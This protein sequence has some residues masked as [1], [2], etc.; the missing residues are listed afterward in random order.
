MQKYI[1]LLKKLRILKKIQDDINKLLH[2]STVWQL[3]LNISKCKCVHYGHKNPCHKY[4]LGNQDLAEDTTE[5]D[6][7]VTFDQSLKFSIH[8]KNMV[9]KAN[10]RLG[11]IKRSFSHLN[12]RSFKLL[13]KS[14]VRPILEY[15]SVI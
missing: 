14:L 3:P 13:Y 11:L 15:C 7:G 10:Q 4:K 2:W 5:K 8:I 1:K 6:V 12:I 9:S